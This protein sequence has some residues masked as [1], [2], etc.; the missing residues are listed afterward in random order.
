[1]LLVIEKKGPEKRWYHSFGIGSI[2]T[3]QAEIAFP[4]WFPQENEDRRR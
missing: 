2:S 3:W 4:E 1:M